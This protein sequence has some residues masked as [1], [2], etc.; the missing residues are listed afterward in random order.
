MNTQDIFRSQAEKPFQNPDQLAAGLRLV[1]SGYGIAIATLAAIVAVAIIGAIFV[2]VPI[3]VSGLGVIL[4]SKG[5]L[6]FTITS[7]HEGRIIELLVDVGQ[8]VVPGQEIARLV[9]RALDNDLKLAEAELDLVNQEETRIRTL[10]AQVTRNFEEVQ[11]QQEA[12][13]HESLGL[14][15]RRRVLLER[16]AEA[17][18]GLRKSGQVTVDRYLLIQAELAEVLERMAARRGELLTLTL[19]SNEKKAQ[20]ERELQALA[21]RRTAAEHQI[22]RLRER[23]KND[24]VIRSAQAGVVSELKVYPGDLVRFDT[25]LISILPTEAAGAS[26]ESDATHLVADLFVPARDGKKIHAGM[27]A[28]IEPTSVRRDVYGAI[29]GVVTKTS[30]VAASPEQLR[31]I[32]RND[33]LVKKLTANGPPFLVT[34]ELERDGKTASGFRWTTSAGPDAQIT[35]GTLLD[36]KVTTERVSMLGLLIPAVKELLR[37]PKA[38]SAGLE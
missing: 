23:H 36:A 21:T 24:T 22:D 15:E 25:P 28:L 11:R 6:E 8:P 18:E 3:T 31:H 1:G 12:N 5:L 10:Q 13:A 32:L 7:D 37:G 2:K 4:S 9:Q 26:G 35:A 29:R 34:V 38:R 20:Y 27:P 33:E 14:L 30:A 17:Q 19:N 16:I